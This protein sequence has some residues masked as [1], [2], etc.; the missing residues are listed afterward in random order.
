[1]R[2]RWTSASGPRIRVQ[3][4]RSTWSASYYDGRTAQRETVTLTVGV[5]GLHLHRDDGSSVFWP[6][7]GLRQTQGA[8]GAE[9]LRIEFGPDPVEA[10]LV[11]DDGL[12]DAVRAVAPHAVARFRPRRQAARVVTWSLGAL[13][14]AA[15]AY[16][17]GVPL[18]ADWLVPKVPV[19]WESSLGASVVERMAPADRRCTH[20]E[21]VGGVRVVLDRLLGAVP[22]TPYTFRLFVVRDD[23]I[24]AFAAPGGIIVVNTGLLAATKSPEQFAG[25]LAHEIQHVTLRHGT[26]AIIRE[27]PLRLATIMLAGNGFET[28]PTIVGTLSVLRYRRGDEAEADREGM[29]LLAAASVD[30]SGMPEFMRTLGADAGE[31]QLRFASYLSSHPATAERV[32]AL[33][34][35]AKRNRGLS[36][37]IA[38][39]ASWSRV[40]TGCT[41]ASGADLVSP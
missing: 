3:R 33:D 39:S 8:R 34:A 2:S 23:A 17:W 15:M 14:V 13:L 36:R 27:A 32:A 4:F 24:N 38:D 28:A 41:A 1:M 19:S 12:P 20:P 7:D 37:P 16:V 25:V 30:A 31:S 11:A 9:H 22:A 5:A 10:L 40:R 35:L 26:R 29:R 21:V 18:L 6:Y